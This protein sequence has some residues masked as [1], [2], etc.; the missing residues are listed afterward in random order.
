[1]KVGNNE[2]VITKDQVSVPGVYFYEITF[3]EIT[4]IGKM[5]KIN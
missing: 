5:V 3:E 4:K 1:M 2:I